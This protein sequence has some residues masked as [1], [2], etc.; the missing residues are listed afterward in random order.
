MRPFALPR[1]R[2]IPFTA[3]LGLDLVLEGRVT[4]VLLTGRTWTLIARDADGTTYNGST[5]VFTQQTAGS[6]GVALDGYFDWVGSSG[7]SGRELFHGSLTSNETALELQGYELQNPNGIILSHYN[8]TLAANGN[9]FLYGT[10]DGPNVVEGSWTATA[11]APTNTAPTISDIADLPPAAPGATLNPIPFTVG[12]DLT[13]AAHLIVTATSSNSALV[14][15]D[16]I[17]FGGSGTNRTVTVPL[18]AGQTGAATITVTVADG[19]GL[20]ASDT[21]KV[22]VTGGGPNTPP[23]I[24]DIADPPAAAPGSRVGP[25][26]VFV[27]DAETRAASLVLSATSSNPALVPADKVTFGGADA[28]RTVAVAPTVGQTGSAVITVTVTDAGGLTASDAFTVT[29]AAAAPTPTA[30]LVGGLVNG[31][32]GAFTTA[33]ARLQPGETVTFFRGVGANVRTAS[34]DVTGDGVPD[35]IGGTGPGPVNQVSVRNGATGQVLGTW[36]VFPGFT[37]GVF[38]AAGDLT[39]DGKAEVIVTPDQGGGPLVALYDGALIAAGQGGDAAQVVRFFGIE[40]A[41]FRGGARPALGDVNGDGAV[42]LIVS[43]GFLGGPRIAVFSG[44]ALVTRGAEIVAANGNPDSTFRLVPDFFAFESTLRNGAFVAAGD[45]T[46]D[47]IADLAFGA[48]PGGAPRVRVFDGRALLA[49]GSFANLD[50]IGAAQRA[51]FF[52]GDAALRG[53]VRVAFKDTTG[54]GRSDLVT[55]SGER[56]PSRVRVYPTATVLA[57]GGEADQTLDPFGAELANGVFVG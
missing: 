5:L 4:P 18:T 14:P 42:D 37:G 53:G 45:V 32:A 16:K 6:S 20:T 24:G 8:A 54:D 50:D 38:V 46:G 15:G 52:A 2:R 29:V 10:W 51:N 1:D 27:S 44:R 9:A 34:A 22:T 57:G 3:R 43:A 17:S 19:G 49:A 7:V 39:G 11:P 31:T 40:D 35:Q 28:Y 25:L 30:L 12:D 56:E 36:E 41:A 26:T 21:F 47:G 55:G 13:P 23:T 33:N 48:G